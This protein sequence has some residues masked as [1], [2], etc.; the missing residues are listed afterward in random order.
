L[1][2]S[3]DYVN[4]LSTS[5]PYEVQ[6]E[7]LRSIPGLEDA[8]ILRP[9]YGIEYDAVAPGQIA[10]SLELAAVPGLFLAGQIN[11]TSGYEEAAAQG[12]L[13]GINAALRVRKQKPFI[14][15][16]DEAYAGVLVDDI[17]ST[18]IEEPYRLFTSRAEHRL[19]LRVDNADARLTPHGRRLGLIGNADWEEFLRKRDR[20]GRAMVGFQKTRIRDE[21]KDTVSLKSR[22]KK[23][24]VGIGSVVEYLKFDE[25]LS[26][27]DMR[28]IEAE[29]KYE[30]YLRKQEK[31]VSRLR[32]ADRVRVPAGLDLEKVHGLT[33][34]AVEKLEKFKPG[35]LGE[36]RRLPGITPAAVAAL[37]LHLEARRRRGGRG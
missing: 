15:R 26:E 30:G 1:T 33:R 24:G 35:T 3:E 7:I 34:E 9:G 32:K 37:Q 18:G 21:K 12:L 16:R 25:A 8:A 4:G 23:P 31:E 14:L 36:A 27:E 6:K 22:L 17:V 19:S 13:A 20:I 29:I 28:H 2:T 10:A 11:G 5:L